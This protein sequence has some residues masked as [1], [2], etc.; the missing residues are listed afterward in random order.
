MLQSGCTVHCVFEEDLLVT[1]SS[2]PLEITSGYHLPLRTKTPLTT[3]IGDGFN[4]WVWSNVG[5]LSCNL[6]ISAHTH[7]KAMLMSEK[8]RGVE[9]RG[10]IQAFP[11]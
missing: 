3:L 6:Y 5:G 10:L 7:V 2:Q 11:D 1:S 9:L 8:V 4:V